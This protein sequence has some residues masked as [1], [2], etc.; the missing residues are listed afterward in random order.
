MV[1]V[2]PASPH[3]IQTTMWRAEEGKYV[4]GMGELVSNTILA[5]YQSLSLMPLHFKLM[6]TIRNV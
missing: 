5:V 2:H 1:A 3:V 4:G 6:T